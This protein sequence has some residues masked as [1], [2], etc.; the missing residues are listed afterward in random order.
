MYGLCAWDLGLRVLGLMVVGLVLGIEDFRFWASG[1][2]FRIQ[3]LEGF[4]FRKMQTN[5]RIGV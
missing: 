5:N 1:L 2:G 3:K 4:G